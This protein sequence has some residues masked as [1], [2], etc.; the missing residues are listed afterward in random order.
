MRS[1]TIEVGDLK[2]WDTYMDTY[3]S[4]KRFVKASGL[5]TSTQMKLS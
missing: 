5:N 4:L 3:R 1:G 2:K